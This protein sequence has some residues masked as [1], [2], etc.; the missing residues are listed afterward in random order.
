MPVHLHFRQERIPGE[1]RCICPERSGRH[2]V[3][4]RD[5]VPLLTDR[6]LALR[7]LGFQ[8]HDLGRTRICPV[9]P[10]PAKTGCHIVLKCL[11][12]ADI[13]LFLGEVEVAGIHRQPTNADPGDVTGRVVDIDQSASTEEPIESGVGHDPGEFAAVGRPGDRRQETGDGRQ[14]QGVSPLHVGMRAMEIPDQLLGTPRRIGGFAGLGNNPANS[15]LGGQIDFNER[16]YERHPFGRLG[17]LEPAFVDVAIEVVARPHG[18][19]E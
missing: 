19:R 14:A 18:L 6:P 2:D 16:I 9:D 13:W 8:S 4:H 5:D 3:V 17:R 15:L 7:D 1:A 11:A 10:G 12:V